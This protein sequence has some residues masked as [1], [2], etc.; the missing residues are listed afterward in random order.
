MSELTT[1]GPTDLMWSYP[2][3]ASD[4]T[5]EGFVWFGYEAAT[6]EDQQAWCDFLNNE[7][8][9]GGDHT[10]ENTAWDEA[11]MVGRYHPDW[12]SNFYSKASGGDKPG[13][14]GSHTYETQ[15]VGAG[16][17]FAK[18]PI[19]HYTAEGEFVKEIPADAGA[20]HPVDVGGGYSDNHAGPAPDSDA[21]VYLGDSFYYFDE[22]DCWYEVK[23]KEAIES[24][25]KSTD[26][27][28]SFCPNCGHALS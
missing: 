26:E 12:T 15:H 16:V 28:Y 17:Q 21:A 1:G 25:K 5:T 18:A 10:I 19:W 14:L 2:S 7:K 3:P 9:G 24:P 6:K 23:G 13:G 27:A 22:T 11:S 4:G 20:Y 8:A